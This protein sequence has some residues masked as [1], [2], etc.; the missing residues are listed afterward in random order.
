MSVTIHVAVINQHATTT[1]NGAHTHKQKNN[2]SKK[3][4]KEKKKKR[5][6]KQKTRSTALI[7]YVFVRIIQQQ[8]KGELCEVLS[9]TSKKK[10]RCVSFRETQLFSL[11]EEGRL[12]LFPFGL[13]SSLSLLFVFISFFFLIDYIASQNKQTGKKKEDK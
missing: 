8:F 3:K 5:R 1:N 13:F 7:T 11:A 10:K 9:A 2:N 12:T 4:K 6:E